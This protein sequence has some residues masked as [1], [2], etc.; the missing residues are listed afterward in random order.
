[1]GHVTFLVKCGTMSKLAICVPVRQTTFAED[2]TCFVKKQCHGPVRVGLRK[3]YA[4]GNWHTFNAWE[5]ESQSALAVL[6]V[7]CCA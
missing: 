4:K 3:L 5:D 6:H 1:M 7:A 2:K